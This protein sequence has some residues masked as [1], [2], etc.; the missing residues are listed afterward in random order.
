MKEL[1]LQTKCVQEVPVISVIQN[2]VC[3]GYV[4]WNTEVPAN[5]IRV[6]IFVSSFLMWFLH[7]ILFCKS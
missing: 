6:T 7:K 3:A 5:L 2:S 4:D 1:Q